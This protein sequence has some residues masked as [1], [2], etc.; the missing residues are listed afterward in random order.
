M[1]RMAKELPRLEVEFE[2]FSGEL[3]KFNAQN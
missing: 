2:R 3:T 1:A